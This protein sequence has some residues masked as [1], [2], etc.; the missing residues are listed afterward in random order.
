MRVRDQTGSTPRAI[1]QTGRQPA[2]RN[3]AA[4]PAVQI[5]QLRGD[6]PWVG[7]GSARELGRL[8]VFELAYQE[9]RHT[10]PSAEEAM[11]PFAE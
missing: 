3:I 4:Q 8:V 5:G 7:A 6:P 9:W 10:V 11:A 2:Q 1:S